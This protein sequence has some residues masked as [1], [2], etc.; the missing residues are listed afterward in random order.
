MG[1]PRQEYWSGLSFPSPGDL[2]N[3]GIKPRSLV[4]QADSLT[5]QPPGKSSPTLSRTL[6]SAFSSLPILEINVHLLFSVA[7]LCLTL[8][9]P[10]DC[11][12][13]AS[14]SFT[15]S[16]SLLKLMSFESV[17][18]SNH[19]ILCHPLLLLSSIFPSIRVFFSESAKELE[20]QL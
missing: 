9:D 2:P 8:C 13:Q 18:P 7:K 12:T 16:Q 15:I 3:P 17:K 4:L 20:L 5:S 6:F 11:R 14:L 1:F 19:F 10:M